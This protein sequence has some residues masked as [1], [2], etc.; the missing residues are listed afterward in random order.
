MWECEAVPGGVSI[1]TP[2]LY[3]DGEFV[4]VFVSVNGDDALVTDAGAGVTHLW[5]AGIDIDGTT[6]DE[7]RLALRIVKA[8]C[9]YG[10][11]FD[12]RRL[13]VR[14]DLDRLYD[15]VQGVAEA[16][17]MMSDLG[18][19]R[20]R[21]QREPF[22]NEVAALMRSAGAKPRTYVRLRGRASINQFDIVL[23]KADR[24]L[25]AKTARA[26][27]P[28]VGTRLKL[29]AFAFEDVSRVK[30]SR[31][32]A[33]ERLVILDDHDPL[34]D[35]DV[36]SQPLVSQSAERLL[37]GYAINALGIEENRTEIVKKAAMYS[38]EV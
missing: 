30:D 11:S 27:D 14:T 19:N 37:E 5:R 12:G 17:R 7:Q 35:E 34:G 13:F 38:K 18:H 9:R 24:R 4:E 25:L 20:Q 21:E 15:A 26:F 28:N 33:T 6:K 10:V 29:A 3:T 32:Q 16:S 23:Y 8:S 22:V 2:F 36:R 31:W 1:L